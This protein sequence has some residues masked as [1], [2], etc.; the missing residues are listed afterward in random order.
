[1]AMTAASILICVVVLNLHHRDP[2]SPPP[3]WLRRLTYDF[4]APIV[5]MR[6][7]R[8]RGQTVYQLCEFAKDYA[9][10]TAIHVDS[11][12][13]SGFDQTNMRDQSFSS[14]RDQ[15]SIDETSLN[16]NMYFLMKTG[17]KKVML[18]EVIQHLRKVT[19]KIKEKD[20]QETL[21]TEW[22]NVAKIL[23]RFFLVIFIL[24][25]FI[26]STVL[27]YVYPMAARAK[28]GENP[29]L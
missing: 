22:K 9:V 7:R 19:A 8:P 10:G 26:S 16:E 3:L 27:L 11:S 20:E 14:V 12:L 18:E 1:M 29:L 15:S 28:V 6:S 17:R 24:L 23:D 25:V 21:K 4:L 2:S 13:D 5:C